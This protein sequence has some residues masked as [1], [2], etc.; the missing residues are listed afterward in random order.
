[1]YTCRRTGPP[2]YR[3]DHDGQESSCYLT[4]CDCQVSLPTCWLSVAGFDCP[5]VDKFF[6]EPLAHIFHKLFGASCQGFTTVR[7]EM[8]E[9]CQRTLLFC[10]RTWTDRPMIQFLDVCLLVELSERTHGTHIRSCFACQL[11][12]QLGVNWIGTK[13]V[14]PTS[15]L[16]PCINEKTIDS[17]RGDGHQGSRE[18]QLPFVFFSFFSP[19]GRGV[20]ECGRNKI[21]T[22]IN[23]VMILLNRLSH[24]DRLSIYF[25]RKPIFLPR[26]GMN[27][28]PN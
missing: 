26:P 19:L 8:S 9:K 1:M 7:D 14:I 18:D 16:G 13:S 11:L 23:G 2:V 3:R 12:H 27:H 17:V 10:T 24:R 5:V 28:A 21:P 15:Y 20:E 25:V 6:R 22:Q 4:V